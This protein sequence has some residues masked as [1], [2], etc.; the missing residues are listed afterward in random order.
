MR[1]PEAEA[2]PGGRG[3]GGIR[4]RSFALLLLSTIA[5]FGGHSL[6]LPVV[7]LL[8][9]AGGAGDLGAG[10]TTGVFML[11][12][13][14]TQL[15]MPALLARGGYRWTL[16]AGSVLLGAPAPLL[17]LGSDLWL[18]I[19]VSAVRGVGF[20]MVTVVGSALAARLVPPGQLGRAVGLYGF[21]LGLPNLL[22]LPAG[23]WFALEVGF[24]PLFVLG[25]VPLL[26]AAVVGG[27]RVA[28]PPPGPAGRP[29]PAPPG[30]RALALL[31]LAPTLVMLAGSVGFS[32]VVTFL[33]LALPHVVAAVP[34]A[35][36]AFSC[37]LMATRWLAGAVSDR[38][39]RPV[40]LAAG[41]AAAA[42]GSGGLLAAM[43]AGGWAAVALLLA[44]AT[45]F[46]AGFGTLQN[47]AL[48]IMFNRS[49]PEGRGTASAMWN[50]AYDA[51]TGLGAVLVGAAAESFGYPAPLAA[52]TVLMAACLPVAL[53]V[54][55]GP[56]RP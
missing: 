34:G 38:A 16:A 5:A 54:R 39:G 46:G 55:T 22:C 56:R 2:R 33:P 43:A 8:A 31:L 49:G 14:V 27:I 36:F 1:S 50:I 53:A 52:I 25:A 23:V 13:V 26:G 15:G 44:G 51:G 37:A 45:L 6:L 24:A 42:A 20:G 48:V 35:L 40:L 32:V 21:A 47:D 28:P 30:G 19:A 12:T 17:A 3:A 4:S 10:A 9:E 29:A 11:T 41:L 7:P 18:V